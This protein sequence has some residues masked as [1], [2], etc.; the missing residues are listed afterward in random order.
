V[1]GVSH[2]ASHRFSESCS[3]DLLFIG[4]G[5]WGSGDSRSHKNSLELSEV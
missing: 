4:A 5:G 3:P 1:K 2:G